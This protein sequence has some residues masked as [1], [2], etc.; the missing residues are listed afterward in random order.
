MAKGLVAAD[1]DKLTEETAI[2][3]GQKLYLRYHISGVRGQMEEGLPAVRDVGLPVLKEGIARGLS[4]NDA[5]CSA[6]LALI[7]ATADTNLIARSSLFTQQ[8]IVARIKKLLS[9]SPYPDK[10]TLYQLDSEFVRE[11]LS[12]GGSADLL[13]VCYFLYFLESGA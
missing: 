12:P 6:L 5:G 3:T 4:I 7:T 8:E 11:N 2:T 13:A 10:R 1:F 9:E